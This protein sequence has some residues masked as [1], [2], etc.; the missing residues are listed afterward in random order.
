MHSRRR[1]LTAGACWM[2]TAQG[3]GIFGQQLGR[4]V[5]KGLHH[6]C[7]RYI[8]GEDF[9]RQPSV[10]LGKPASTS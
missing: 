10:K 3:V 8:V 1:S 7:A 9:S 5:V 2:P 4:Q 6:S